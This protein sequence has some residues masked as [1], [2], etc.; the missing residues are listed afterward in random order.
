MD[1]KRVHHV[2]LYVKD[3]EKS[4]E[5]YRDKLGGTVIHSFSIGEDRSNWLVDIGGGAV[6]ELI[7]VGNGDANPAVGWAHL[8]VE[9]A[10]TRAAYETAVAAGAATWMPPTEMD[11]GR[12]VLLAYVHGP[13]NEIIE[14]YQEL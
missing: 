5:F 11:I 12:Q 14:F 1:I 10:D 2:G 9:V 13:D 8:A 4:L 3:A 6:I 7:P